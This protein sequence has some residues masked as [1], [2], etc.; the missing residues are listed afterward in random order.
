LQEQVQFL[1]EIR[2]EKNRAL[3]PARTTAD[4]PDT[5]TASGMR[6]P[7]LRAL[8]WAMLL[9]WA[10]GV[11]AATAQESAVEFW[12]EI[13]VWMRLSPAWR[14]S[15]FVPISRNIETNYR[16]GNIVAQAD[17]AW[18]KTRYDRRLLDES[19]AQKMKAFLLRGGY[20]GGKS[21]GDDGQAYQEHTAFAEFHVRIP[22]K[23]NFLFSHRL[24]TDLR[25]LGEDSEYSQRWRYRLMIEREY[26][27]GRTSI[28][29]Y[30]NAE[31]YFDSR[32]DTV[33]RIRL[34]GGATVSWTPRV[35]IEG[36]WTYQY[37]SRSSVT[38]TDAF[39]LILHVFFETRASRQ[40]VLTR[41]Q[42]LRR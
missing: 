38:Y 20:L 33:N 9:A 1:L 31:P 36:N 25:W 12:P 39:N 37:D 6:P 29:P 42:G 2:M 11:G 7:C 40:N 41:N 10:V 16:E 35:A 32:Y 5:V 28:V 23:G 14:T 27:E 8:A 26:I 4:A 13:D 21:L 22:L 30:V 34:I 15:L 17:Y 24:R 18:G 3:P 19:R